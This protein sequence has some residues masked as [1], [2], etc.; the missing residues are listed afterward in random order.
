M[1]FLIRRRFNGVCELLCIVCH[2][3][4]AST[5]ELW[6]DGGRIAQSVWVNNPSKL[7]GE[8]FIIIVI[9]AYP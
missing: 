4:G 1:S 9:I 2:R 6:V 8:E 3:H 5:V 7:V